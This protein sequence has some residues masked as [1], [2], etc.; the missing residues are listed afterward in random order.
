MYDKTRVQ[1]KCALKAGKNSRLK[2]IK[3]EF[4]NGSLKN[5]HVSDRTRDSL[6]RFRCSH[7]TQW[8]N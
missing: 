7:Q 3:Y 1:Q 6:H 8:H 4:E 5:K 2:P